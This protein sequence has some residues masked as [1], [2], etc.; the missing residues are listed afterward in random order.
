MLASLGLIFLVGLSTSAICRK[1]K[2]PPIIGM[3]ITGVVLGPY[4][5]DLFAP[6]FLNISA[7][8]R[9]IALIIILLK[10]GLSL[11]I[12]DLKQVGRP[13]ILMSFIPASFEILGY[14]IFA[15]Y[16]IGITWIEALVMGATLSAVSPAIVVP[17]MVNLIEKKYGTAK[18]IPQMILSAASCDDIFV[19]VLFTTFVGMASGE[20]L[21]ISTLFNIPISLILGILI[22]A[23]FGFI[24]SMFFESSYYKKRHIR[25]TTKVIIILG[26]SFLLVTAEHMISIPFSGL[27]AIVSMATVLKVKS[28]NLGSKQL[29]DK[30]G[31]LWIAAELILFVLIGAV[32]D[33]SYLVS[34]SMSAVFMIFV[35]IIIRSLGVVLSLLGTRLNFK[36]RLFCV[37]AYLPKA[38]V[39]AAI[40][41][42]PLSMGL[43]CGNIVLTVAVLSIVIT[44]PLGAIAID[45]SYEK[46][47]QN[48]N[49]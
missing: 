14:L 44:A 49:D 17:R 34:A 42:I 25:N 6:E 27:L 3:L 19:I 38:T 47:L 46:L 48:N 24:L 29:A 1:I 43:S 41:A 16:I 39:Q 26:L 20:G 32:V 28:A 22:G 35:A 36:E 15:P 23:F 12:S 4:V 5:L 37:F 13:A 30:F 7:D 10:A 21:H 2:L 18:S 11:N 33:I 8:L 40:G 45:Y 9:Q 31:S